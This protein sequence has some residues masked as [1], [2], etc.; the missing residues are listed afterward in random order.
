MLNPFAIEKDTINKV[1]A[2]KETCLNIRLALSKQIIAENRND[3][4]PQFRKQLESYTTVMAPQ[5]NK[6]TCKLCSATFND[7]RKLGG[8]VS[9]A[10]KTEF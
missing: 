10:H 6:Y 4:D 2:L 8:H 9:R 5:P 7:G 3:L 1:A